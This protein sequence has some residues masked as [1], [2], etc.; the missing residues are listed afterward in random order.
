MGNIG[1]L[2]VAVLVTVANSVRVAENASVAA[3]VVN[4]MVW[5]S[6]TVF[7]KVSTSVVVIEIVSGW[8]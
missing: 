8:T 3:V 7:V 2:A 6:E 4:V 1:G 5:V